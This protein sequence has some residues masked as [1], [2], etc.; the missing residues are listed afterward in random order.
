MKSNFFARAVPQS[1][2]DFSS[3]AV[4][5]SDAAPSLLTLTRALLVVCAWLLV[6]CASSPVHAQP[7]QPQGG[8]SARAPQRHTHE[9]VTIEFTVEPVAGGKAAELVE[10]AE[11]V[12]KFRITDGAGKPVGNL[13]PAA[14]MHMRRTEKAPDAAECREKVRSFLQAG[15]TSRAEIDLNAYLILALNHEPNISVIDPLSGFGTTKLYTLVALPAP[16]EDWVLSGDRKTLYVSVPAAGQ[17]VA[18]DT[19][20]WKVVSHIDAGTRPTRLALQHDKKYLWVGNDG[21]AETGGVTAI[22]TGT[23]KVAAHIKTGAGRHEI[24]FTDDDRRVFVTNKESG[25]LTVIDVPSLTRVRE[26]KVGAGPS[27]LAFS[28]LGKAVYVV[29]EGDGA[30]TVV[31][32]SGESVVANLK[33]RPGLHAIGFAPDGRFGFVVNRAASEVYIFDVSNNRLVQ[34]VAVEPSPDQITFTRDFAYV[35]ATGS[36]F[37]STIK[38][39]DLGTENADAAAGR[40]PAGQRAPRESPSVSVA[41]AVVPAPEPGAVLAANPAD[42]TIYYYSEGMAAPMGS[43]TNYRRDPRAV[44]VLDKSLRETAP[45]VYTTTARFNGHGQYDVAFLLDS[46]RVVGCFGAAVNENP[47]LPKQRGVPIKVEMLAGVGAA[48]VGERH[49]LRFKVTDAG[50]NRPAEV[51]DMGTLVFLAP[52]IWQQRDLARPLGEGVYEISFVPPQE[53]VY[54]VFFQAPSLGVRHQH[55]PFVTLS[56]TKPDAAPDPKAAR[57]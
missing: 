7:S 46:P 10:G 27:A 52:G 55:L 41:A 22:D 13:R 51:K 21:P 28:S 42:K 33:A 47:E 29:A 32:E 23:L 3:H 56:A 17:V 24:A 53:G 12:V 2:A 38:L 5:G 15:L 30:V 19:S 4:V 9:G 18:V 31:S 8:A 44:L 50:T 25:T 20:T 54:Y 57:P 11:A 26:H 48:R 39:R 45:G 37:V 43:F 1:R 34:S 6:V 16:G 14:W 49:Q 36:E 40:F 35:R